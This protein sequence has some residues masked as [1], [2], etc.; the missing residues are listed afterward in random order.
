MDEDEWGVFGS[1]DEVDEVDE[2][3]E[4]EECNNE[5]QKHI[6]IDTMNRLS[7][8]VDDVALHL[9]KNWLSQSSSSSMS[10]MYFGTMEEEREEKEKEEESGN[11][12]EKNHYK[13]YTEYTFLQSLSSR[14]L[15]RGVN[16]T[17]VYCNEKSN[18]EQSNNLKTKTKTKTNNLHKKDIYA[19][20]THIQSQ[21]MIRVFDVATIVIPIEDDET[22][23]CSS[24]TSNWTSMMRRS[25]VPGGHAI[26]ILMS[27][28]PFPNSKSYETLLVS[29]GFHPSIWDI[30]N[31]SLL[32]SM[33]ISV[34]KMS[35][36]NSNETSSI[37]D[38]IQTFNILSLPKRY[39][40]MNQSSC[41]WKEKRNDW[42][43]YE[44]DIL[45]A[46]TIPLS[47]QER[48]YQLQHNLSSPM[49][50]ILDTSSIQKASN[51]LS[52]YG[53]CIIRDLYDTKDIQQWA[54]AACHDLKQAIHI[55]KEKYDINLLY[56]HCNQ[57]NILSYKELAMR[58]DL[59]VDIR[60]GPQIRQLRIDRQHESMQTHPSIIQ[61]VTQT[62]HPT[63]ISDP[64]GPQSSLPSSTSST[65][66][67]EQP[68]YRGNFGLW[69]FNGSGPDAP[70]QPPKAHPFG[71]VV[72]MPGCACQ[73][74]HA[75]TPHLFENVD[76]IP[77]HYMNLFIS[78]RK[79][80]IKSAS[81]KNNNNP[82][83]EEEDE[84]DFDSEWTGNSLIGGT[85]FIC[86]SHRL[87]KCAMLT[88]ANA[89][90]GIN[91]SSLDHLGVTTNKEQR[92]EMYKR[93]IRPSLSGG[94]ALLFDCRILHFGLAN[95]S[96]CDVTNTNGWRP[97]LYSNLTTSWFTDP[98]NWDDRQCLF[99]E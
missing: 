52:K 93:I 89:D 3:E 90:S 9:T 97:M 17:K 25:I 57:H 64:K 75:D 71:F 16:V 66:S 35:T 15:L 82:E 86:E 87:S 68:L 62:F 19:Y 67:R 98:K 54:D 41:E 20:D 38:P 6:E 22:M 92:E 26:L 51:A 78:G 36:V 7:T 79:H 24:S 5:K 76:T 11:G 53:F 58:E 10:T 39:C 30:S 99:S 4:E 55:L 2:E 23:T 34:S 72:S 42:I 18:M 45:Q 21:K 46:T 56:P 61:I 49:I 77:P 69:N 73:A 59:R 33:N 91:D 14:L 32:H 48:L 94:D 37:N 40:L 60:D 27:K 43:Q 70:P 8:L 29:Y 31:A 44:Y 84:F 63:R 1:D 88:T 83:E 47:A 12:N 95:R 96:M 85:A 74:I 80:L 65:S 81:P 50:R 28:H 13:T